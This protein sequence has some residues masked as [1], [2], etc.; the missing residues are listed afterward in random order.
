[1]GID[2]VGMEIERP[3]TLLPL[4]QLSGKLQN[5]VRGQF[6]TQVGGGMPAVP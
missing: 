3:S 5:A 2:E 4:Q 1:M 6:V